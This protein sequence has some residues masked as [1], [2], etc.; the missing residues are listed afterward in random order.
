[1]V[2]AADDSAEGDEMLKL[3]NLPQHERRQGR[4]RIIFKKTATMQVCHCT[5]R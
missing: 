4:E 5:I 2:A 1:M 3:M